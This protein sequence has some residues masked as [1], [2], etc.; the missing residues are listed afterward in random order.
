MPG[1]DYA[2]VRRAIPISRVLELLGYQAVIRRGNRLRGWCPL[3]ETCS[4]ESFC[5]DLDTNLFYCFRCRTGGNQ[6]D[7]WSAIHHLD[8]HPA[9]AHLCHAAGIDVPWLNQ[10]D[11]TRNR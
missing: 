2:A 9:A 5:V 11:A 1:I 8:L 4:R 10:P 3:K 6:L 7:L